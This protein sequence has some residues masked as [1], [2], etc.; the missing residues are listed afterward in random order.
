MSNPK[1]ARNNKAQIHSFIAFFYPLISLLPSRRYFFNPAAL[2]CATIEHS[3]PILPAM[4]AL[5]SLHSDL[6][7]EFCPQRGDPFACLPS[8]PAQADAVVLAGDIARGMASMDAACELAQRCG[9][10]VLWI[11]GNHEY[12]GSDFLRL[13]AAFE[14]RSAACEHFGVCA[15][16]Y[17]Q[18]AT[19]AGTRFA[20]CTLWTDFLLYK[21]APRLPGADEAMAK[22]SSGIRDFSAIEFGGRAFEPSDCAALCRQSASSLLAKLRSPGSF[23]TSCA[24]THHGP[25]RESVAPRYNPGARTLSAPRKLPG[26]NPHWMLNP[27]FA[28]HLPELLGSADLFLHGHTHESIRAKDRGRLFLAAN[29]RGYPLAPTEASRTVYENDSYDESLLLR[30]EKSPCSV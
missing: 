8:V 10:P 26:E 6:H 9:K 19:I 2:A 11:A 1:P 4:S 14:A 30:P 15:L 21:G 29:P 20:G 18:T 12:Y 17:L 23:E 3:F 16:E 22:A 24:V 5:I 7:L 28:S 13:F 27:S 25:F